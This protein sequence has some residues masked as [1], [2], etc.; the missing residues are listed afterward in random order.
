MN[1]V[2]G[3]SSRAPE[4]RLGAAPRETLL[5]LRRIANET[6]DLMR[7]GRVLATDYRPSQDQG[8]EGE[9]GEERGPGR[10]TRRGVDLGNVPTDFEHRS[11]RYTEPNDPARM[12]EFARRFAMPGNIDHVVAR[13]GTPNVGITVSAAGGNHVITGGNDSDE[14]AV[15][16]AARLGRLV[17][18]IVPGEYV[19][20]PAFRGRPEIGVPATVTGGLSD[21]LRLPD[22][23]NL[24]FYG[25]AHVN[26]VS[27][28]PGA[29]F[30]IMRDDGRRTLELN[31][32]FDAT[33]M[34]A[35]VRFRGRF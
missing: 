16:V 23:S 27:R 10:S 13:L 6:N 1:T 4:S 12:F 31:G 5:G 32:S 34:G 18:G 2:L 9:D 3:V 11:R 25:G 15:S 14:G 17:V 33:A 30:S 22:G 20:H 21:Q 35:Q 19:T 26:I 28:Q 8:D 29:H 24:R 7:G